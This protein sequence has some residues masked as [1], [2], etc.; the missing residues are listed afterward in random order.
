MLGNVH[1]NSP[2]TELRLSFLIK[3]VLKYINTKLRNYNKWM[4]SDEVG[5]S[6]L[7]IC[8]HQQQAPSKK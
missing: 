5:F 7:R 1:F 6:L 2:I 3:L 4:I 8:Q